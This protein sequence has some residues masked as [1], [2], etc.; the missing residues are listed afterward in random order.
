MLLTDT[1]DCYKLFFRV[2]LLAICG[3]SVKNNL[4]AFNNSYLHHHQF[5]PDFHGCSGGNKNF[6]DFTA[7]VG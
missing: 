2:Y 4:A 1:F 3:T 5:V 7:D 6:G